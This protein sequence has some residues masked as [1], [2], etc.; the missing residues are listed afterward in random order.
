MKVN[1]LLAIGVIYVLSSPLSAAF[2]NESGIEHC[3]NMLLDCTQVLNST[4]FSNPDFLNCTQ[5]AGT[6]LTDY[7][8]VEATKSQDC[9]LAEGANTAMWL[10]VGLTVGSYLFSIFILP[11]GLKAYANC[12]NKISKYDPEDHCCLSW[13]GR[14]LVK[15]NDDDGD[16]KVTAKE[17]IS[18]QTAFGVLTLGAIVSFIGEAYRTQALCDYQNS[19]YPR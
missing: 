19:L 9:Y 16:G 12:I 8:I 17:I 3:A 15:V 18:P 7:G 14:Q 5:Q 13:L 11:V 6:C 1:V 2:F 4:N 10:I